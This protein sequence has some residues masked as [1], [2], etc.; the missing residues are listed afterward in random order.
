MMEAK[1]ENMGSMSVGG[2]TES[3]RCDGDEVSI[4]RL[5]DIVF[6]PERKQNPA[7]KCRVVALKIDVEGRE[8]DV[9]HGADRMLRE[10]KPEHIFIERN[11]QAIALLESQYNYRRVSTYDRGHDVHLVLKR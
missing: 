10:C 7:A 9:F 6:N 1:S 3:G 5:D 4:A 11:D 2:R 8:L